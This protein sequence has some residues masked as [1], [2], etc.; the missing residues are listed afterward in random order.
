[1]YIKPSFTTSIH[2]YIVNGNISQ[3]NSINCDG[4]CENI[5]SMCVKV[6]R[7]WNLWNLTRLDGDVLHVRVLIMDLLFNDSSWRIYVKFNL[8]IETILAFWRWKFIFRFW[9]R[10]CESY[11]DEFK[12]FMEL[13]VENFYCVIKPRGWNFWFLF[14]SNRLIKFALIYQKFIKLGDCT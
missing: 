13:E 5:S 2:S 4:K 12:I 6:S 9:S 7:A 8:I 3:I 14:I 10:V 1:M 11:G